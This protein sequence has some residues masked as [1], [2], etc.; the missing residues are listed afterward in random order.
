MTHGAG[1]MTHGAG[2]MTYTDGGMTNSDGGMTHGDGGM[3]HGAGDMTHGAGDMTHGDGGMTHGAGGMSTGDEDEDEDEDENPFEDVEC[4]K[5]C[6]EPKSC[7]E[8][9]A[10][11]ASDGCASDCDSV[12]IEKV[13]QYAMDEHGCD[14][15]SVESTGSGGM[16]H[17][18]GSGGSY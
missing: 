6:V 15:D 17:T 1:G 5:T 4:M 3:T 9:R 12:V 11:F 14:F 8:G 10:Q 7:A 2:D 13:K 16:T 18:A